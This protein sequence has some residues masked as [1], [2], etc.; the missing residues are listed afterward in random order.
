MIP[1]VSAYRR[2]PASG[3]GGGGAEAFAGY[4]PT[5]I[6]STRAD[7]Q[8]ELAAAT[9]G[10]IIGVEPGTYTLAS[11]PT[12]SDYTP[13]FQPTSSGTS[14]N[15]IRIV[16]RYPAAMYFGSTSLYTKLSTGQTSYG[17]GVGAP[18]FGARNKDYV[19]W[20][21]MFVDEV[22]SGATDNG[23][24]ASIAE[25]TGCAIQYC[26]IRGEHTLASG[27]LH[28]AIRVNGCDAG[29][30]NTVSYNKCYNISNGI[31][32]A[33]QSAILVL[34][35]ANCI[36]EHNE[37]WDSSGGI[38]V[39]RN[40]AQ[41]GNLVFRYNYIHE[42]NNCGIRIGTTNPNG[43]TSYTTHVHN[44]L[45]VDA[46]AGFSIDISSSGT[47]DQAN[48]IFQNNTAVNCYAGLFP[49][50]IP[51]FGETS[52]AKFCNNIVASPTTS[53]LRFDGSGAFTS[54]TTATMDFQHNVYYSY[55]TFVTSDTISSQNM[56]YWT[57]TVGQDTV[58]PAS[59]TSDPQ[60]TGGVGPAAYKL[61]GAS[62]ARDLGIDILDL[63][64]GGTSASIH[65]GC[66]VTGSETIGTG[67]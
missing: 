26:V 8:T 56:A 32:D 40:G 18:T 35:A 34:E 51:T 3:G 64:G 46:G 22:D 12:A 2:V 13:G 5:V 65:A 55:P 49:P 45:C 42:T 33:N 9:A 63:Q 61:G 24:I 29:A 53:A 6:V 37:V 4:T 38:F 10:T 52:G 60:F 62:P 43:S 36:V 17:A 30:N 15:P 48:V 7:L 59:I 66:Y 58:S 27:S 67:Y 1:H 25:C 31:S 44:N 57:G 21:G 11:P 41:P 20:I 54:I 19:E 50:Y 14:G 47:G 28:S 39:K 16:A 23:G